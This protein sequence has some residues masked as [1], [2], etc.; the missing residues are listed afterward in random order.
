MV[1]YPLRG[2]LASG[3]NVTFDNVSA[4]AD[5]G[6]D[7]RLIQIAAPSD[8]SLAPDEVAATATAFTVLVEC[9]K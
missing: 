6:D 8:E 9:C 4:L 3:A 7:R 2:A 5:P 1:G